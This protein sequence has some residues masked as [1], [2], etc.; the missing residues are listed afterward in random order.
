MKPID[1]I[2]LFL[3]SVLIVGMGLMMSFHHIELVKIIAGIS[4]VAA[5]AA[6]VLIQFYSCIK[7]ILA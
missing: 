7:E 2:L 1:K 4:A 3:L 6:L 5:G